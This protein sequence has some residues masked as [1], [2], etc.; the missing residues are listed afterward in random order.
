LGV[1][2]LVFVIVLAMEVE[3]RRRLEIP[4]LRTYHEQLIK[5]GIDNY[6]WEQL[7]DDYRLCVPMGVYIATEYCWDG[8]NEGLTQYWLPKLQR[9]LAA[10]DDLD[11]SELW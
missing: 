6:T 11:C 2:D 7:F 9:S 4:I 8:V 3:I 5:N 1:Y 10:C